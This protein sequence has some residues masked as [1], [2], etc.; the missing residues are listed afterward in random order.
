MRW[1][2]AACQSNIWKKRL[3]RIFS[4][5]FC[6]DLVYRALKKKRLINMQKKKACFGSKNLNVFSCDCSPKRAAGREI[7]NFPK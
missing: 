2:D 7:Y 4:A 1:W 5:T 3:Q 6:R